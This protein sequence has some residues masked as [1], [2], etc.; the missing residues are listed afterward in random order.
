MERRLKSAI[1][2]HPT[3]SGRSLRPVDIAVRVGEFKLHAPQSL[4][5]PEPEP[6]K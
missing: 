2:M 5:K 6:T 3:W 4:G 1:F